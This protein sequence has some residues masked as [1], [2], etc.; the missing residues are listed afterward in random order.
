MMG[1]RTTAGAG[2]NH[3][4]TA[5]LAAVILD[6]ESRTRDAVESFFLNWVGG[7]RASRTHTK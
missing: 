4:R 6:K 7:E 2:R 5:R 1:Q 3:P